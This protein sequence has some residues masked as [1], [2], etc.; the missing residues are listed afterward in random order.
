[1]VSKKIPKKVQES[2]VEDLISNI[3]NPTMDENESEEIY[4]QLDAEFQM[5]VD[6][7]AGESC[8]SACGNSAYPKCKD[9]CSMYD[10]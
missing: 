1:M 9:S 10:D 2:L 5:K 3:W 6:D 4:D 7:A 8:C